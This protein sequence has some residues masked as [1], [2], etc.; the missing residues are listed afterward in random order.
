M[1]RYLKLTSFLR[2]FRLFLTQCTLTTVFVGKLTID[3][4]RLPWYPLVCH[5]P[6]HH[7]RPSARPRWGTA[8]RQS[9]EQSYKSHMWDSLL[10][11]QIFATLLS[12]FTIFVLLTAD[13]SSFSVPGL[14][15]S[16]PL[17]VPEW[18]CSTPLT[19]PEWSC[20]TPLSVPECSCSTPLSVPC[21]V[22]SSVCTLVV[23]QYSPCLYLSSLAVLLYLY[24]SCLAVLP[25]LYLSGLAVL[26]DD[27]PGEGVGESRVVRPDQGP[28]L[29][30][31][32]PQLEVLKELRR[33]LFF[34]SIH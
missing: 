26:P 33:K 11:Y 24:L 29:V 32:R 25:C 27:N 2:R 6:G 8:S 17:S 1:K 30:D 9:P 18:S 10:Y 13:S 28:G 5:R 12:A 20:S 19:V 23:L 14:Y 15:C 4:Q 16:T 3:I 31:V 21:F 34:F 7:Q 22:F